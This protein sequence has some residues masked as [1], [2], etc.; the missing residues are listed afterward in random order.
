MG[1]AIGFLPYGRHTIDDDDVAAVAEVLRGDW[2]TTGPAVPA[3]EE[4]LRAVTGAAHAVVVNSGTAALYATSAA[5][6]IGP[7]DWVIV[8]AITFAATANAPARLGAGVQFADVDP[9]TALLTPETLAD[10]FHQAR[11]HDRRVRAVFVVHYAGQVAD[12]EGL[13]AV[14]EAN[15]AEL[16][17]DAC[18]ALGGTYAA[19]VGSGSVGDGRLSKAAC[20]SFH[21]VKTIAMGE[22]GAVCTAD[23]GI[24]EG[25]RRQRNHGIDRDA[26]RFRYRDLAFAADGTVNPWYYEID[27]AGFNFRAPDILCALGT[28]QLGKLSRFVASRRALVDRYDAA[29][30]DLGEI[31]RP[32]ARIGTGDPAWHLYVV[33][34]DFDSVGTTRGRVMRSLLDRAIGTQVHYVPVPWLGC[35]R[36]RPGAEVELPGAGRFYRQCLSLPLFPSMTTGDVDR[37]VA[38]V[39]EVLAV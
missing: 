39:R 10:A 37:V 18:H 33:R 20:F 13:R 8:P 17:E 24:A 31:V 22:G 28:S 29:F 34:I 4:A 36:G 27:E 19:A 30:A 1:E 16:V 7:G 11:R 32:L 2:L 6:H 9:E 35:Y 26:G 15:G 5:L 14:A 25:V 23:A 38:A 12:L 21:P 3:F